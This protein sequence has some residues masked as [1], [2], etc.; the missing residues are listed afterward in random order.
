MH[1]HTYIY[2]NE[3]YTIFF[4]VYVFNFNIALIENTKYL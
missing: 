3:K 1:I 2:I 4:I